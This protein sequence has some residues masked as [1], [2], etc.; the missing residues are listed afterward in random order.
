MPVLSLFYGVIVRM[1]KEVSAKHHKAH[2][3]VEYAGEEADVSGGNVG[4]FGW[5]TA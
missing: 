4:S 3:H 2:I 1:Y 5:R